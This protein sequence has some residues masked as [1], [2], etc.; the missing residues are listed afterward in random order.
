VTNNDITNDVTIVQCLPFLDQLYHLERI[1]KSVSHC[2]QQNSLALTGRNSVKY[3]NLNA[4]EIIGSD[5]ICY[6]GVSHSPSSTCSEFS[7]GK[8]LL[9]CKL[10]LK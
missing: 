7:I 9:F 10:C 5:V 6:A 2:Y 3:R 4:V 8:Y 1:N